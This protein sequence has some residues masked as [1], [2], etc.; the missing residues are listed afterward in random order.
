MKAYRLLAWGRPPELC[1]LPVPEPGP[2]QV[3]VKVAGAGACHTD[4]HLMDRPPHD[5]PCERPPFT[6]GHENAGWVEALG[7]GVRG[8]QR[9]DAV[10]V[11]G[12]WGCGSCRA[13]R[14]GYEMLCENVVS[15][16][17]WGGGLGLDGGM[18]EYLLVPH[19]RL[20]APLGELDPR[21][22]APLTDAAL[23]PYHAIKACLP[24]LTA[25]SWALVI[26]IGG[27]GHVAVQLLGA[28]SPARVLAVDLDGQK[29]AFARRL[30]AE[31]TVTAGA[32]AAAEIDELTL[33]RGASV[34]LD[35][36]GSSSTMALAVAA[37]RPGGAVQIIGLG[38]GDLTLTAGGLPFDCRLTMPF[39]GSAP[40]LLEVIDLARN[41]RLRVYSERFPLEEVADV[42]ARLRAGTVLGRAVITPHG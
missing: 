1:E 13:C 35:C 25:G 36:V 4:L 40:E 24:L 12:A 39:W 16:G 42:Y 15:V 18:A 29:L 22:A 37:A 10:A 34:V 21:E 2:G 26:G 41:G 33:G 19:A 17:S 23:T 7:S 20:L 8:W 32:S 9:G 27:L 14:R 6:L 31:A 5:D 38:G 3:L 11:Y 28:L 30:G